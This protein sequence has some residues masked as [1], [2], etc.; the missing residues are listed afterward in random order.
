MCHNVGLYHCRVCLPAYLHVL[1]AMGIIRRH[2][3]HKCKRGDCIGKGNHLDGPLLCLYQF[4][5]EL[6]VK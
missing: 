4:L 6:T 2:C 1:S 3:H 5:L